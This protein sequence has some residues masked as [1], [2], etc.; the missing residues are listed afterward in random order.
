MSGLSFPPLFHGLATAGTDPFVVACAEARKGCDA[1]LVA[2]DLRP[3]VMRAAMVFAPEVPLREAVIMLPLC[4]VGFQNALGALAPPEVSVHLEWAGAIR[5]N[6]G[7]CGALSMAAAPP[8]PEVEPDWLV[9]GIELDLWPASE[10]TG[11]TPDVTA[12]F[13]EGCADV[14]APMLLEA[15]VRHT[16]VW[17]NRWQEDGLRPV[18][19]EWNGIVHDRGEE[20]SVAGRTGIFLGVDEAF[21]MLLQKDGRTTIIPLTEILREAP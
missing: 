6:G 11:L 1:G 2:Y 17:L 13:T 19:T 21:G 15:W 16:L 18:H 5:V 3:D 12:L 20:I 8:A 7:R 14:E 10:E 9:V 4:G